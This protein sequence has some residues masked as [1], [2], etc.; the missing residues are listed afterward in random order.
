VS[1]LAASVDRFLDTLSGWQNLGQLQQSA[2]DVYGHLR[3]ATPDE[4]NAQLH[5]FLKG[6]PEARF[7]EAGVAALAC[8]AMVEHGGDPGICGP[9][10]LDRTEGLLRDLGVFWDEVR[11]RSGAT[12]TPANATPLGERYFNEIGPANQEAA[13]AFYG[14]KSYLLGLVTHLSRSPALRAEARRRPRLL[15]QAP[16]IDVPFSEH[17]HLGCLLR[18]LDDEPLLVLHPGEGKGFRVRLT[19]VADVLQLDTLL[20]A[21]LGGRLPGREPPPAIVSAVT[22]GP[23]REDL[24][25]D[26]VFNLWTW[27]GLNPDGTLPPGPGPGVRHLLPWNAFPDQIPAF[28]GVRVVLLAPRNPPFRWPGTRRYRE[29][30]GDLRVEGTL[31]P[32]EVRDWLDRIRRADR[33]ADPGVA[34]P[35]EQAAA[36]QARPA[37]QA[38]RDPEAELA[39]ARVAVREGRHQAA[40][41]HLTHVVPVAPTHPAVTAVLDD[42]VATAP[43]PLALVPGGGPVSAGAAAVHAYAL[44]KVGRHADAYPL[45]CQLAQANPG[46]ALIDWALPWLEGQG[47]PADARSDA[48][49]RFIVSAHHRFA[50]H[51]QLAPEHSALV[52]RW[53]PH[54]RALLATRPADDPLQGQFCVLLRQAG[55]PDEAVAVARARH[56]RAPN[57]ESAVSLA[58]NLRAKR[59]FAGWYDA[60]QEALK[61]RPDDVATRL[62][63]ADCYWEEQQNLADAERWYADALRVAP[64]HPWAL[65]SLLAVRYLWTR[66]GRWRDQLED[67][68]AA[69]SRNDRGHGVLARVTP[70]F[71]SFLYPADATVNILNGLAEKVEGLPPGE[72]SGTVKLTTTGLDAPSCR[73]SIDRQ[74]ELW[75]GKVRVEREVLGVQTPDPRQPRVPVRYRL[76]E[77]DDLVPRPAVAP[78]PAAVAQ[79]VAALAA[80]GYDLG[81]WVGSAANV[82]GRLGPASVEGLLGVMAHPPNSPPGVR[83]WDWTPRVQVAAALVIA[84]S[85]RDWA[86]SVRRQ[87]LIDLANGP[88]DWATV[89]AVVALAAVA[90]QNPAVAPEVGQLFA[91]V[92]R[93]LP[94]PG[95]DWYENVLLNLHLRLPGLSAA[96][97]QELRAARAAF[98]ARAARPLGEADLAA[99]LFLT[100]PVPAGWHESDLARI[101][102]EAFARKLGLDNP[103]LP[104]MLDGCL[105]VAQASVPAE[106]G[107]KRAYAEEQI[108][109]LRLIRAELGKGA[110]GEA[111]G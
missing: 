10:L 81:R 19:G 108:A 57:F 14:H 25:V 64:D 84:Q 20:A 86:G 111:K 101:L 67:H 1:N 89:A 85:G 96:Q 60:C 87:A 11:K 21:R 46:G 63:L 55:E 71:A 5:R 24:S 41:E 13:F 79:A 26:G 95:S 70:F 29:M 56:A 58:A 77:Y 105:G 61:F 33:A 68:V 50:N 23:V 47:L 74:V 8:G 93:D 78:P 42:L 36:A 48:A 90:L 97:V 51:T 107:E 80:T 100:R 35:R 4:L 22:D 3:G 66:E 104:T 15:Q 98:E 76:W 43:D 30:P 17:S 53:L 52:R 94:R 45:L 88:L 62:D 6:L 28:D 102:I 69:N 99:R 12:L 31:S 7:L 109:V 38:P 73:R 75:G 37:A 72:A 83:A 2:Q 18:V 92:R 39:A 49:L 27:G 16:V 103:D 59:E 44:G 54:V 110:A 9:V 82:A 40:A 91:E 106:A 32:E 34:P 65:P